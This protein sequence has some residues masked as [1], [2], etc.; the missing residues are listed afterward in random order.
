MKCNSSKLTSST[1]N[2]SDIV[3]IGYCETFVVSHYPGNTVISHECFEWDSLSV[4][5][6]RETYLLPPT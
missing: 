2:S 4:N 5:S 3:K 6:S 1:V